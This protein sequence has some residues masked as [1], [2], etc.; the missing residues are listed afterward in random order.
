MGYWARG[1][2]RNSE[3]YRPK[4]GPDREEMLHALGISPQLDVERVMAEAA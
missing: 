4:P 2:R 1:K 3:A